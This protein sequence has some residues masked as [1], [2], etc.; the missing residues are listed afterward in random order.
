MKERGDQ[1]AIEAYLG[2]VCRNMKS[3]ELREEVKLEIQSHLQ[4]AIEDKL[5][6]GMEQEEAIEWVI[7]QMGDPDLVGKQMIRIHKPRL[8]WGL[9]LQLVLFIVVGAISMYMV[10]LSYSGMP[11][12]QIYEGRLFY[13]KVVYSALGLLLV[14]ILYF[15][16]YRKLKKYSWPLYI[17]TIVLMVTYLLDLG[18]FRLNWIEISPYMLIL[19]LAGLLPKEQH[20]DIGLRPELIRL[21]LFVILPCLLYFQASNKSALTV[22]LCA[23]IVMMIISRVN[24]KALIGQIGI[25]LT[26]LFIALFANHSARMRLLAFINPQENSDHGGYIYVQAQNALHSAGWFGQG[27]GI[28]NP[29]LPEIHADMVYTYFVHSLGWLAGIS[30][31]I[32]SA[33]FLVLLIRASNKIKDLYGKLLISGVTAILTFQFIWHIGMSI[34]V[35]PLFRIPLPFVGHGGSHMLLQMLAI[36]V[37]L[38]VYRRKD[39]LRAREI[40]GG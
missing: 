28:T 30:F 36:G 14:V 7:R 8:H 25:G 2:A 31:V 4:D 27:M 1:P 24:K 6:S 33:S 10:E 20:T 37:V 38:S 35:L 26:A 40:T 5:N 9:L 19:A 23:Y 17:A 11:F 32:V 39:L 34:G 15:Y 21:L 16:D 29:Y 13:E 3:K 12:K 22:Y 18:I